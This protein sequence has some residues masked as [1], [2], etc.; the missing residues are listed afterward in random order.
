MATPVNAQ[1][2]KRGISFL[3]IPALLPEKAHKIQNST[4]VI[5]TRKKL[6][7]KAPTRDGEICFTRLRLAAKKRLVSNTAICAFRVSDM[8]CKLLTVFS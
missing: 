8:D 3:S 2:T 7:P 4:N 5:P 1:A 6:T